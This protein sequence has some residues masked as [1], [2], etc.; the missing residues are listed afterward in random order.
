VNQKQQTTETQTKAVIAG[1]SVEADFQFD[2]ASQVDAIFAGNVGTSGIWFPSNLVVNWA[3]ENAIY[4]P[5]VTVPTSSKTVHYQLHPF[6]NGYDVFAGKYVAPS[7]TAGGAKAPD[8][9]SP[10]PGQWTTPNLGGVVGQRTEASR[11]ATVP[12]GPGS[13]IVRMGVVNVS[14][15]SNKFLTAVPATADALVGDPG[16]A[17]SLRTPLTFTTKVSTSNV[18]LALPFGS[19]ILYMGSSAGAQ[20]TVV[21]L[22]SIALPSGSPVNVSPGVFT[23]D[24]RVIQ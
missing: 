19:W 18:N 21:P 1:D 2:N 16:C 20:T 6:S 10:D 8:C 5:N 14:N 24:P 13:A 17:V 7:L 3:S 12:G 22:T 9:V 23:I 4:S 11:V 15:V